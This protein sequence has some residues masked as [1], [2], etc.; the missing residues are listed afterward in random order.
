MGF[1]GVKE[2]KLLRAAISRSVTLKSTNGKENVEMCG[3]AALYSRDRSLMTNLTI[4]QGE[5][6]E[7]N[8]IVI[9]GKLISDGL[10]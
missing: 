7:L 1:L 4:Y 8:K 2:L 9:E 10:I 3:E 6:K 5:V